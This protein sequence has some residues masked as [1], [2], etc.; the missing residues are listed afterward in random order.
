LRSCYGGGHARDRRLREVA[1]GAGP[2]P[3]PRPPRGGPELRPAA[4]HGS[5]AP[6]LATTRRITRS[7]LLTAA[8][9]SS[10]CRRTGTDRSGVQVGRIRA[11]LS[12]VPTAL[13]EHRDAM[14]NTT[15]ALLPGR[16][17][18]AVV[19]THAEQ[20]GPRRAPPSPPP[21]KPAPISPTRRRELQR[22]LQ[23]RSAGWI[24]DRSGK[25]VK[26]EN[27]EF[28]SDEEEPPALLPV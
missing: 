9:Y 14:E 10:C 3:L 27:A 4:P 8:P 25:W 1:V 13:E 26:D 24:Q 12:A 21:N 7:A 15:A 16:A 17:G 19:S 18:E 23:L 22:I 5:P 2:S 11:G 28:D 6:L 20:S